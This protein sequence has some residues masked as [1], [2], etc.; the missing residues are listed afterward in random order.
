MSMALSPWMVRFT[1]FPLKV[2]VQMESSRKVNSFP[3]MYV[4]AQTSVTWLSVCRSTVTR[5]SVALPGDA[6]SH[7]KL[8]MPRLL[9]STTAGWATLSL[10]LSPRLW[11][12]LGS[13]QPVP[14]I[15]QVQSS[16]IL[17]D[18]NKL[19]SVT[20][21]LAIIPYLQRRKP[22]W[23]WCPSHQHIPYSP[24]ELFVLWFLSWNI[25]LLRQE[26]Y[27]LY[28]Y[29]ISILNSV[30][31]VDITKCFRII[32][33]WGEKWH[34]FTFMFSGFWFLVFLWG[35]ESL[36][37][38]RLECRGAI[39]AHCNLRLLGSSDPLASVS[40]VAGIPGSHHHAWLIFVFLVEMGFHHVG[41]DGLDLLTSRRSLTLLP[42]LGVQWCNLSSLQ[43]PPLGVK[44]FS[45]LSLPNKV[46]LLS[47]RLEYNDTIPWLTAT[48]TSW[49]QQQQQVC[50]LT[51]AEPTL[52]FFKD[53]QNQLHCPLSYY[54][55]TS[56]LANWRPPS[57]VWIPEDASSSLV[58]EQGLMENDCEELR[59]RLQK[60]KRL[61][62]HMISKLS[63]IIQPIWGISK[64]CIKAYGEYPGLVSGLARMESCSVI[65]ARMQ[66][67]NQSWLTATSTSWVQKQQQGWV[68]VVHH[69]GQAALE[70][71]TSSDPPTSA[72]Q[73]AGITGVSHRTQLVHTLN[74]ESSLDYPVCHMPCTLGLH[75]CV[76]V[77]WKPWVTKWL[78]AQDLGSTHQKHPLWSLNQMLVK[79]E[80]ATQTLC[81]GGGSGSK[82]AFPW[83]QWQ[84]CCASLHLEQIFYR[85]N[86]RIHIWSGR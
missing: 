7:T 56:T 29:A 19:N 43:P 18:V 83:Q 48:S 57:E 44:Q 27:W 81:R 21:S 78:R 59:V 20:V 67:H 58:T 17:I 3:I 6:Y 14:P 28:C 41:Q 65:Q 15:S 32:Y 1:L 13:L 2:P 73:S 39:L 60:M 42:G 84:Q 30:H 23:C 52:Q 16:A 76:R 55:E 50:P 61:R 71:L 68:G 4:P 86:S 40:R 35:T 5:I 80:T 54:P 85:D 62:L 22:L 75:L 79:K 51:A 46:S 72:S 36:S 45:C 63:K 74:W 66:W 26:P 11:H 77:N 47:P 82:T 8:A 10:T 34:R 9:A 37:V 69:V 12:N 53:L 64:T 25:I 33:E 24:D 31:T 49:V 70:L 38:T